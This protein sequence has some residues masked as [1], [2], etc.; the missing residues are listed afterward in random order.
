MELCRPYWAYELQTLNM[1][2]LP[3]YPII[4]RP[5]RTYKILFVNLNESNITRILRISSERATP[6]TVVRKRYL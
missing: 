5:F 6:K 3:Y 2:A 4:C 1:V